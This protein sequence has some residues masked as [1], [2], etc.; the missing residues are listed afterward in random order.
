MKAGR[1]TRRALLAVA[2]LALGGWEPLWRE[3]PD[4]EAGNRAYREQRYD[5]AV[6]AYGRAA[7]A[8]VDAAGLAYDRG[9][10]LVGK[11]GG[12][13]EGLD[14]DAAYAEAVLELARA[15]QTPDLKL[16]AK[17]HFNRGNVL[18]KQRKLDEAIAAYKDSLRA[19]LSLD[20]ARMNLELA[21][22]QREREQKRQQ[23]QGQG[24]GQQGSG[25]DGQSQGGSGG[26]S[27][28]GS[29]DSQVEPQPG[30]GGG[31]GDQQ[32][33]PQGSGGGSG[34]Q[35]Q[36]PPGSAGGSGG[37][38]GSGGDQDDPTQAQ[39]GG[40]AGSAGQ[41]SDPSQTPRA[42]PSE[43]DDGETPDTPM[44]GKLDELER[45]SREQRREH[46]RRRTPGD[47]RLDRGEDW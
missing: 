8:G 26:G 21:L 47:L 9:T 17:A 42:Q 23:Q 12:L 31:S 13:P 41:A 2:V 22:R 1:E 36:P 5:D 33:L 35:Q 19:D 46:I 20:V 28:D 39:G 3:D 38:S 25:G 34:D 24:Q 40:G 10:A 45:E 11:A 4:V 7:D 16:R 14:R 30:S 15:A 27:S 29:N 32:Q 43:D 37:G 6:R 44:A 18:M